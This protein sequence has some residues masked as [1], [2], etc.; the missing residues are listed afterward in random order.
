MKNL[1]KYL[2]RAF[3]LGAM[4]TTAFSMNSEQS[5]TSPSDS[6]L[7]DVEDGTTVA[8]RTQAPEVENGTTVAAR[9]QAPETVDLHRALVALNDNVSSGQEAAMVTLMNLGELF[10]DIRRNM[11]SVAMLESWRK[12]N[13]ELQRKMEA[14]E[15][16][17]REVTQ[18]R[19]NA[20][21]TITTHEATI[22]ELRRKIG[23]LTAPDLQPSA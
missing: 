14:L 23:V 4:S 3:L 18:A 6:S 17:I 21:S 2:I 19:D 22:A 15:G 12:E 8:T 5:G 9:T 1:N 16:Q 10:S 11:A 7:S 13:A 20:L